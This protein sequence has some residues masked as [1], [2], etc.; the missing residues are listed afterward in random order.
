MS[1]NKPHFEPQT[2]FEGYVK[3]QLENLEKRFDN[4]PCGESFKRLN[5]T[6]NKISNIEGKA[7]ILGILAGFIAGVITRLFVK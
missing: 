2:A 7:T 4:L 5:N 3:A 1:D 6:E